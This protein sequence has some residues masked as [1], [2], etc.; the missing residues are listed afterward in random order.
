[1]AKKTLEL[2][3]SYGYGSG[4]GY[5]YGDGSG[6]GSGYGYG[7]GSGSGYGYGYGYGYGSGSGYGYGDGYGDGD[8]RIIY[9][10]AIAE[11]LSAT[12]VL[13]ENNQEIKREL[14]EAMGIDRFFSQ[15]QAQV[16]HTDIDI[17][18][19]QRLLLRIPMPEAEVGYLQAVRVVCPT[20]GR[21][22]H[23][24]VQPTVK[25]CKEAVASTFGMS[26]QEYSPERE[27]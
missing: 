16:V 25:T 10:K 18:G 4:S 17:C 24:G 19:N 7:S 2:G 14:I 6:Y 5:G 13:A 9:W 12:W 22:Y 20:T 15:L 8:I 21:I 1:M 27:T 3:I 26:F 11:K 23:L